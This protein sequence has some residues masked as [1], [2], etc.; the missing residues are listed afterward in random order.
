MHLDFG[1]NC[2]ITSCRAVKH[3]V[4]EYHYLDEEYTGRS[5]LEG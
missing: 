5:G 2:F 4:Y 1:S 3:L